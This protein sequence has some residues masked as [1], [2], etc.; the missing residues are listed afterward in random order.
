MAPN[1]QAPS[2]HDDEVIMEYDD[3]I[4]NPEWWKDHC[5]TPGE[6][7]AVLDRLAA[8]EQAGVPSAVAAWATVDPTRLGEDTTPYGVSNIVNGQWAASKAR[9]SIPNP[10]DKNKPDV[11]SIPDTAV[12]ELEPFHQ[13]LRAVPKTGLH[14]PLKNNHR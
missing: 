13:S 1:I 5:H 6:K 11:F 4:N 9:M 12:D 2:I 3:P 10:M 7:A 8:A 14:N